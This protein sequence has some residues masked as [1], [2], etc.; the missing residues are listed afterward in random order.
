MQSIIQF[1]NNEYS[2]STFVNGKDDSQYLAY[3][4]PQHIDWKSGWKSYIYHYSV[5]HQL[6]VCD[7]WFYNLESFHNFIFLFVLDHFSQ[8]LYDVG[9]YVVGGNVFRIQRFFVS[10]VGSYVSRFFICNHQLSMVLVLFF[11]FCREIYFQ[12]IAFACTFR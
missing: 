12:P 2:T 6:Q 4:I 9:L 8:F 11:S 10:F 5:S 7:T 3:A 1:I